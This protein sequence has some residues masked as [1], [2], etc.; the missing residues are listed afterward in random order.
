ME[1]MQKQLTFPH[2]MT[3]VLHSMADIIGVLD[4]LDLLL[5]LDM[6]VS[7]GCHMGVGAREVVFALVKG[8]ELLQRRCECL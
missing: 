8:F 3:N 5:L 4:K 2:E 6:S 7:M 1:Q